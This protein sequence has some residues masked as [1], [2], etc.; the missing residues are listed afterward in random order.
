MNLIINHR[1]LVE[2]RKRRQAG[3][4]LLEMLVAI[5][6]FMMVMGAVF[7]I[8]EVARSD[9]FTTN[10]RAEA[11]QNLRVALTTFD[12]D[13]HNA[14]FGFNN[15][16]VSLA[17]GVL[18][19]NVAELRMPPD[20][21]GS[22]ED[23]LTPVIGGDNMGSGAGTFL[24]PTQE[25]LGGADQVS[26]FYQDTA[27]F[28]PTPIPSATPTPLPSGY[29]DPVGPTFYPNLSARVASIS[30]DGA[31]VTL[32][33][34][35]TANPASFCTVGDLYVL[36]RGNAAVMG[37][38]TNTDNNVTLTFAEGADLPL[39]INRN[40]ATSPFALLGAGPGVISLYRVNWVTYWV[41]KDG[42]LIRSEYGNHGILGAGAIE[43]MPVA[44]GIA[45]MQVRYVMENG[46]VRDTPGVA[47][48]GPSATPVF[49]DN[50]DVP[51]QV[52]QVMINLN[53]RGAERDRRTGLYT[54]LDM[55]TIVN[56]SN[57][58]YDTR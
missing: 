48:P 15:T 40:G 17:N 2:T 57:I 52:R 4:S 24:P 38:L 36:T 45:D 41:R 6:I 42:A 10:Q 23:R 20:Q 56:T 51:L 46:D 29:S 37:V 14:G 50:D 5:V 27:F 28:R 9:R 53:Y 55:N 43:H 3:F 49:G 18:D 32:S 47:T 22:G 31:T 7:G 33:N 8:M 58:G 30:A 35:T 11:L 1:E 26:F 19:T 54:E 12:R 25:R 21:Y 13:A 34:V 44:Y 16:G 39:R